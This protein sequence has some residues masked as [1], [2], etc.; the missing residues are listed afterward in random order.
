MHPSL[1]ML[2][3]LPPA[4]WVAQLGG[5]YER[6]PWVAEAVLGGRPFTSGAGVR[7]AMAAAVRGASAAAQRELIC[8]H[9]DLGVRLAELAALTPES[10]QEQAAAGLGALSPAQAAQLA[11]G[12][13][14]Y[15]A[16]CGFPFI[17]CA[18]QH[19]AASILQEME[20]R[21]DN[22]PEHE[23]ATALEELHA[24]ASFRLEDILC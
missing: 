7:E 10:R 18:R 24:I 4:A 8:A 2:N 9:P 17:I 19:T 16:R 11:A 13:A 22:E 23:A 6:S 21:L 20:R 14:A 12:N 3:A 1:E 5:V 15:R